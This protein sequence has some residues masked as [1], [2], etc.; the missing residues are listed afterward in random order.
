MKKED[1][2]RDWIAWVALGLSTISIL[3]WLCKYEPV[4]W[5]LLD[6]VLAVFSL[7]V[8]IIAV[9]FGFNMFGLK[10]ELK[11]DINEK[12]QDVSDRY[13]IHAAK[14]MMYVEIRLLHMAIE[15]NNIA[16]IRQ[17]IFMMLDTTEKTKNKNDIDYVIN[18]LKDLNKQYGD[19]LF[20]STFKRKLKIRLERIGIFSDSA[21]L[22][23]QQLYI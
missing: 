17:S 2:H 8:A 5:T 23:L 20:D 11:K 14:T 13:E 6:S 22:F 19:E 15:L 4:T 16:D 12:L 10:N 18:Q 9:L 3:L 1:L 7:A 21:T